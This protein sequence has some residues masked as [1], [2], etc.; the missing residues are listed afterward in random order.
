MKIIQ[1]SKAISVSPRFARSVSLVRDVEKKDALDGYILTPTGRSVLERLCEALSDKSS[2]RAWSLTGPY[3]SGKTAFALLVA[4]LLGGDQ[5]VR[6]K[7]RAFLRDADESLWTSLVNERSGLG[8]RK[9]KL[10]P[11]LVTGS[12]E[13]LERALARALVRALRKLAPLGRPPEILGRLESLAEAASDERNTGRLVALYEEVLSYLER[14][15]NDALGILLVVDELGKFLEYGASHPERGDVFALQELAEFA[16]RAKRPFLFLTILH[17]PLN[18]YAEHLPSSRRNEWA[19]VE[20]RFEDIAFEEQTEQILRLLSHAIQREGDQKSVA[21]LNLHAQTLCGAL[22]TLGMRVGSLGQSEL[23]R[24]LTASFPLHPL[25]SLVLGPLFRQLAQNERSL[26]SFLTSNE[27]FGFQAFLKEQDTCQETLEPFRLDRLYDYVTSALAPSLFAHRRGKVWSEVVLALERLK[28]ATDLETRLAKTIGLLQAIGPSSGVSATAPALAVALQREALPEESVRD[29]LSSLTKQSIAVFKKHAG[30]YA[31]WEGSDVDLDARTQEAGKALGHDRDLAS[32]LTGFAPP[33]PLVA[34]RHYLQRGTLRF[35]EVCYVG[36]ANLQSELTRDLGEADGR[37]LLC[38][39]SN[40]EDRR[41]MHEALRQ[42]ADGRPIIGALPA[43]VTDLKNHAHEVACLTWVLQNTPEL[44][45]DRAARKE[46]HARLAHAEESLKRA[47]RRLFGPPDDEA[48]NFLVWCYNGKD[49][50]LRGRSA[51]SDLLSRVCDEVYSATPVWRNELVNRRA[52][53]SSAAAG[54]RTL[55]EAMIAH[56]EVDGLGFVGTPPERAMY[57]TLLRGSRLHRTSRGVVGFHAPDHR[58]DQGVLSI[59]KM[60]EKFLESTVEKRRPLPELFDILR[61]PP[62]GLREG[63]LPV[64]LAAIMLH[65]HSELGL[66]EDGTFIP[67]LSTAVF[68]RIIRTPER[69][70]LQLFQLS[71]PR[72]H[73]F[74]KYAE[75][76]TRTGPSHFVTPDSLLGIVR[77]LIK[78]G[79]DLP[80]YTGKTRQLKD[81]SQLVLRAIKEAREPD[82]LLFRDLP[83][84]CGFPAFAPES[85]ASAEDVDAYFRGLRAA[86]SEL[87]NAYPRLI[88]A[89]GTL[90]CQAFDH[91][92]SVTDARTAI[93]HKAKMLLTLAIDPKLKSFLLRVADDTGDETAWIESLASL[94]A[95]RPSPTWDDQDRARFEVQLKATARTFR[96]YEVLAHEIARSGGGILNGDPRAFRVSITVP[97]AGDFERV[98]QI[99]ADMEVRADRAKAALHRVL[100][101]EGVL[102]DHDFTVAILANLTREL[103]TDRAAALPPSEQPAH[104]VRESSEKETCQ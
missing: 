68:E 53:S 63:V 10:C 17:Q 84:A 100:L 77:P 103:L 5:A 7:A 6:T 12:R 39:P 78:F 40:S 11:V 4:Q 23:N 79:R 94:L 80:E 19:K 64:L 49:V 99:P 65:F 48:T 29:A 2:T 16:S 50:K 34:K 3:G 21:A 104:Q 51:L 18:R 59:W 15:G 24:L 58:A 31:L 71:G 97:G 75:M 42:C 36:C 90:I 46:A 62:N 66:Y 13:P 54:R 98:V 38:L 47:L 8:E 25:T 96:H 1:L 95:G 28:S 37:L 33:Q 70:E 74:M 81:T 32:V 69:F 60:A 9:G 35:F 87:Q 14:Y 44:L 27:P 30:S 92:G 55:I 91:V 89:L 56:P 93:A 20:G 26:F 88:E 102:D 61:R 85:P 57:E 76:L 45:S 67:K 72:A 41:S 86:L 73:V 43:P 83:G 22:T 101:D 82:G 52:L